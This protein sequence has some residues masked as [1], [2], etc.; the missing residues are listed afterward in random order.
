MCYR[1]SGVNG[2]AHGEA[3]YGSSNEACYGN[4]AGYGDE[5]GY[6]SSNGAAT[7]RPQGGRRYARHTHALL[8]C[9]YVTISCC[10]PLG[11]GALYQRQ[12][13]CTSHRQTTAHQITTSATETL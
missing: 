9:P 13:L 6:G 5:A 12:N 4:E 3:C 11:D 1:V 8:F 7:R 10:P 2:P